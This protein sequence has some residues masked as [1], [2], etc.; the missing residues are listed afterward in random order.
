MHPDAH[1][2]AISLLVICTNKCLLHLILLA[3]IRI[4]SGM[5]TVPRNFFLSHIIHCQQ[6]GSR[7]T[8]GAEKR[9]KTSIPLSGFQFLLC[10][11]PKKKDSQN[12]SHQFFQ[13]FK[14]HFDL[15]CLNWTLKDTSQGSWNKSWLIF[16]PYYSPYSAKSRIKRIYNKWKKILMQ[17]CS[18]CNWT[19]SFSSFMSDHWVLIYIPEHFR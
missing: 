7:K 5:E 6:F 10:P 8:S 14:I 19:K 17:T 13:H 18:T 1:C 2:T 9:Q 15:D 3:E 11:K 16:M 12:D 4:R